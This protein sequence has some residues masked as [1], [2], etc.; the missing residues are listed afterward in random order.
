MRTANK[1]RIVKEISV[2]TEEKVGAT[3]YFRPFRSDCKRLEE[4]ATATGEKKSTIAQKLMHLA[5]TKRDIEIGKDPVKDQIRS[6][7]QIERQHG[8]EIRSIGDKISDAE[9]I[10][11]KMHRIS[12][13]TAALNSEVYCMSSITISYLN[14][15]FSKL[16]E[17]LS[18]IKQE[19]ETSTEIANGVI[20]TLIIHSMQELAKCTAFHELRSELGSADEL[21]LA[22]KINEIKERISKAEQTVH[23]EE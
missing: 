10:L 16:L 4:L 19:R 20:A 5:L 22:T 7:V 18:P 1:E 21:Y 9:D 15:I 3:L 23:S 6:L 12:H 14:Q 17:F 11:I 2:E 8:E 13:D